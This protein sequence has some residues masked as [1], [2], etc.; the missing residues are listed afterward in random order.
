MSQD[1]YWRLPGKGKQIGSI[2]LR[3]IIR[4]RGDKILSMSDCKFFEGLVAAKIE[5]AQELLDLIYKHDEI[6][7][8]IE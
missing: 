1:L 2:E 3:E 4:D 6:E 8:Y 5:G 7:V